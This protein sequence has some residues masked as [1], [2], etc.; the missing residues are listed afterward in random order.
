MANTDNSITRYLSN[1][2]MSEEK[3]Q[4]I[5]SPFT[6]KATV[7]KGHAT[8]GEIVEQM[9]DGF[10]ATLAAYEELNKKADELTLTAYLAGFNSTLKVM[11]F[12]RED[13]ERLTE[14]V[15]LRIIEVGNSP[16]DEPCDCP[17]CNKK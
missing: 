3:Q 6:V 2:G 4:G 16:D 7:I 15:A 12:K 8:N 9:V 5:P 17:N 13:A 11:G 10:A 14:S 1:Y